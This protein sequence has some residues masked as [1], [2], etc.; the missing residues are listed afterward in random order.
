MTKKAI[1]I[2][3]HAHPI[4]IKVTFSFPEFVSSRKKISSV[5]QRGHSIVTS[6]QND[7]NLDPTPLVPT[8]SI[9]VNPILRTFKTL[10]HPPPTPYKNSKLRDFI[11]S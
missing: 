6:S 3:D 7:Q 4:I 5:D 11:V 8:C 1:P 9:L 10:H 2:F